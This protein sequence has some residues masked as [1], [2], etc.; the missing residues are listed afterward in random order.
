MRSILKHKTPTSRKGKLPAD[1]PEPSWLA[2]PGHRTKVVTKPIFLLAKKGKK[3]TKCTR[4][5][6]LCFKKYFAYMLRTNRNKS[7]AVMCTAAE[8]VLEHLFKNHS[9]CDSKWCHIRQQE[10]QNQ[11]LPTTTSANQS[12]TKPPSVPFKYVK[13]RMKTFICK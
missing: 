6:A 13:S 1:I 8:A 3:K 7:L 11:N 2:D 10:L 9:L 5:D 4:V 12:L